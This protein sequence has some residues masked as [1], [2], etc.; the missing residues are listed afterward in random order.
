MMVRHQDIQ[1]RSQEYL[2]HILVSRLVDSQSFNGFSVVRFGTRTIHLNRIVIPLASQYLDCPRAYYI[3]DGYRLP[4]FPVL[5]VHLSDWLE[6]QVKRSGV[7]E[8]SWDT[9][10]W[11]TLES[12]KYRYDALQ[13]SVDPIAV[14]DIEIRKPF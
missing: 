3:A 2:K 5:V 4:I 14:K 1:D 10:N 7:L 12:A 6:T 9:L 8:G 13:E 11:I